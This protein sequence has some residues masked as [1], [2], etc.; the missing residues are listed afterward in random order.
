MIKNKFF[1]LTMVVVILDHNK[2]LE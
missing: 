1:Y 2:I